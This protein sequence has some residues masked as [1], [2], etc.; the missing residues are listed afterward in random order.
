MN[1][2]IQAA[3]LALIP[4]SSSFSQLAQSFTQILLIRTMISPAG[5]NAMFPAPLAAGWVVK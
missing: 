2:M 3:M 4:H 5:K 1:P